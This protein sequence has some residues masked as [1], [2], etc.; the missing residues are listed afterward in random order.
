MKK[1]AVS[2]SENEHDDQKCGSRMTRQQVNPCRA[3]GCPGLVFK[4]DKS[5]THH[6]HQFPS[7]QE[8]DCG[9]HQRDKDHRRLRHIEEKPV[10][11]A[12][13]VIVPFHVAQRM[14]RRQRSDNQYGQEEKRGKQVKAA[15]D[16]AYGTGKRG[17]PLEK[18]SAY[19]TQSAKCAEDASCR[20]GQCGNSGNTV[21][22]QGKNSA[23]DGRNQGKKNRYHR[24]S[25][26]LIITIDI[27]STLFIKK[28]R[29][30]NLFC[31]WIFSREKSEI[32]RLSMK[33]PSG[34]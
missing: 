30:Y 3:H 34:T 13:P 27:F 5:K 7:G 25:R 15:G 11:A 10:N 17:N 33:F 20:A 6:P 19:D 23:G 14:Q 4:C 22:E 28:L 12:F 9:S 29:A 26:P 21:A 24:D 18:H 2:A 32:R 16:S 1:T 31:F 8:R